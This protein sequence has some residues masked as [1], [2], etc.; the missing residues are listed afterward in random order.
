MHPSHVAAIAA[1][2]SGG[3]LDI[4]GVGMLTVL[5]SVD[6]TPILKT[7]EQLMKLTEQLGHEVSY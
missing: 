6:F 4:P 2:G 7:A 5:G 1:L 3:L